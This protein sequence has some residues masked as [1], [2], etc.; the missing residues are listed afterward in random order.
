MKRCMNPN[1]DSTL[2]NS[3]DMEATLMS[4]NIWKD[5]EHV[6]HMYNRILLS[7]KKEWTNTICSNIDAPREYQWAKERQDMIKLIYGI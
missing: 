2:Y 5:K 6:T 3:Q 1:G 7:H 4:I